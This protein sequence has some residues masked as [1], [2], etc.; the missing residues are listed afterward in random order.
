MKFGSGLRTL[1]FRLPRITHPPTPIRNVVGTGVWRLTAVSPR[2]RLLLSVGFGVPNQIRDV[3][4]TQLIVSIEFVTARKR[5]LGQGNIFS[6]SRILF[7]WGEYTP[8]QVP[9]WAGIPWAGTP[10][11]QVHPLGRYTPGQ[12]H[13]QAGTPPGQVHPPWI[14][15]PPW[16]GTPPWE[17]RATIGRYASYWNA[18]LL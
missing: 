3:F 7:T 1:S 9:L 8:E 18:F 16:A 6:V 12:A 15:T 4:F 5:S 10:P 17:I 14:G 13:P 2:Y 11:G